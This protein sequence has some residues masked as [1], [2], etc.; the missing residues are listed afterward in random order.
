MKT[1]LFS[2]AIFNRNKIQFLY[3][4][5]KISLEP[6]YI[7]KNKRG[8]K[9]L[10]GRVENSNE[11]KMFEYDKIYNIKIITNKKFSPI[12]PILLT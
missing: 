4:M 9:V 3:G 8:K 11:I 5:N 6:Y 10:Y 2:S 7:S 12:I 1:L